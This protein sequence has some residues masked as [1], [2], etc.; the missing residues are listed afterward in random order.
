MFF[1]SLGFGNH[2]ICILLTS[3][4]QNA[5]GVRSFNCLALL[6]FGFNFEN[7]HPTSC[8]SKLEVFNKQLGVGAGGGSAW[9]LA[10]QT[11][12]GGCLVT[13]DIWF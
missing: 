10:K 2:S 9:Q 7:M 1:C 3:E 4:W 6:R 12:S 11:V 13:Q 5:L 8:S